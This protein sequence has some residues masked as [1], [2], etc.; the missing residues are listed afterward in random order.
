MIN[1]ER[2]GMLRHCPNVIEA[3]IALAELGVNAKDIIS[4]F[5]Q[6]PNR[7]E[8][9]PYGYF[10]SSGWLQC[11]VEAQWCIAL[12]DYEGGLQRFPNNIHF[13]LK[14]AKVLCLFVIRASGLMRG[15]YQLI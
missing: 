8:R 2:K 13:L 7:S 3:I 10:D 5:L 9:A 4:L 12:N 15:T 11:Y 14:I 1:L 6:T